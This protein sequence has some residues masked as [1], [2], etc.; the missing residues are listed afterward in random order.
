MRNG[1]AIVS[2]EA[3]VLGELQRINSQFSRVRI[4]VCYEGLNRHGEVISKETLTRAAENSLQL[5]PIVGH[6]LP[7]H[8]NFGGHDVS[9][10][11]E[12]ED[13][14]LNDLTRPYG[15]VPESAN[16]QWESVLEKDGLTKHE[17]LTCDG[18]L[19]TGR[20]PKECNCILEHGMNQS[21][22]FIVNRWGETSDG[23][24]EILD[25]EFSALCILGKSDDPNVNVEPCY[26]KASIESYSLKDAVSE[27]MDAYKASLDVAERCEET[28]EQECSLEEDPDQKPTGEEE[29]EP[30]SDADGEPEGTDPEPD[31]DEQDDPALDTSDE[32]E[33]SC[34]QVQVEN[35]EPDYA[36]MCAD[37]TMQCETLRAEL[38]RTQAQC[39]SMAE[40]LEHLRA[41]RERVE[42]A[43]VEEDVRAQF[44]DLAGMQE[45]E[46]MLARDG[47]FADKDSLVKECYALRGKK[48]QPEIQPNKYNG[49]H[50]R[51]ASID[52]DQP[53][54]YNGIVDDYMSRK[55]KN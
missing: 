35:V 49:V 20:Y 18:I 26:E 1:K 50:I 44:C 32:V 46:D 19:W 3:H 37:L 40:E 36:S 15:V 11:F 5:V 10:E 31:D 2:Y 51:V 24:D 45:F 42:A 21:M 55:N 27:I 52:A 13:L 47:V 14:K 41:Y 33:E 17:Y 30:T 6:Y 8:D 34:E 39:A 53:R 29:S 54:R 48:A 7:E 4:R 38:E 28:Q 25:G 23:R 9:L 22:E 43:I 16:V 12:G